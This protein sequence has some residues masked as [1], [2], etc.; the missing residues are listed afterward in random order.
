MN[1]FEPP[2]CMH[3][4]NS[5]GMPQP[6]LIA[7]IV[8]NQLQLLGFMHFSNLTSRAIFSRANRILDAIHQR[9]TEDLVG[10]QSGVAQLAE[11]IYNSKPKEALPAVAT[12]KL[13]EIVAT[14]AEGERAVLL[15]LIGRYLDRTGQN[16]DGVIY[17][18]RCL[19]E[20]YSDPC[21]CTRSLA[22]AA[23]VDRGVRSPNYLE[24][25]SKDASR[26]SEPVT[27]KQGEH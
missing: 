10:S 26:D 14:A 12:D 11:L 18:K 15:Y 5:H 20:R 3:W 17:W 7:S 9:R 13:E 25:R 6:S 16:T 19:R 1:N 22:G 24:E 23:L 21:D 2:L 27:A 4:P 8:S